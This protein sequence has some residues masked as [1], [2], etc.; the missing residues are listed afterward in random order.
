M[1]YENNQYVDEQWKQLV[2]DLLEVKKE[3]EYRD[4][5]KEIIASVK[6]AIDCE[7]S[8]SELEALCDQVF[9]S[10]I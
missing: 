1:V 9:S 3:Q 4:N 8:D 2:S 7:L 6:E 10:N 5:R